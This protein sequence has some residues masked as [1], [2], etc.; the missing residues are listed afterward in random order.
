MKALTRQLITKTTDQ[1]AAGKSRT[2]WTRQKLVTQC[3]T[4]QYKNDF[5]SAVIEELKCRLFMVR[6]P[7][8]MDDSYLTMLTLSLPY[9]IDVLAWVVQH[10]SSE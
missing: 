7:K 1:Q 9:D 10:S 8:T 6:S 4:I 5:Y 3:N 2:V